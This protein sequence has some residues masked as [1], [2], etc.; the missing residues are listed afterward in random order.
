VDTDADTD[1]GVWRF[2]VFGGDLRLSTRDDDLGGGVAIMTAI[3]GTGNAITSVDWPQKMIFTGINE[4]SGADTAP[5]AGESSLSANM[6]HIDGKEAIDGNDTWLRLNQNGGFTSGVFVQDAIRIDGTA[7]V[8]GALK[9]AADVDHHMSGSG[10]G[11]VRCKRISLADDATGTYDTAGIYGTHIIIMEY[12]AS[13]TGIVSYTTQGT[14]VDHGSGTAM[15]YGTSA[16]PDT[17]G[18]CN[19]WK[20]LDRQISVKNRMGSTRACTVWSFAPI[21]N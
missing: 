14:I 5:A 4:F 16:N 2:D 13:T 21:D 15:A 17:D 6:L 18:K 1:E 20:S 10:F 19:V 3:R 9:F 8:N 7:T 12:N 11:L